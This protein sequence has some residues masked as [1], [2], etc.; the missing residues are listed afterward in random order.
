MED[1][2]DALKSQGMLRTAG[3]SLK[4]GKRQG[5]FFSRFQMEHVREDTLI[6]DFQLLKL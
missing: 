6:L 4:A 5:R 2:S 3:K 1:W